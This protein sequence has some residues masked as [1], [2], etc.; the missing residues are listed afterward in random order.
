MK[1]GWAGIVSGV[2]IV[3]SVVVGR[4]EGWEK[5]GWYD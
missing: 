3:K 4:R 2:G 1:E 5:G